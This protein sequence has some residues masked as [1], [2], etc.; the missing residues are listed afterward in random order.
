MNVT[1][2]I[3][4]VLRH[5]LGA[6]GAVLISKG[7][8]DASALQGVIGSLI[9]A[10]SLAWAYYEK[11]TMDAK[12]FVGMLTRHLMGAAGAVLISRGWVDAETMATLTGTAVALATLGWSAAQKSSR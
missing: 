4:L 8:L 9:A 10:A 5:L 12:T 2:L 7:F 1:A 11:P 3:A 6:V